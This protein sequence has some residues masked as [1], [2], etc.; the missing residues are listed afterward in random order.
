MA[1]FNFQKHSLLDGLWFRRFSVYFADD[2]S[3][4]T[5]GNLTTPAPTSISEVV[6]D[7]IPTQTTYVFRGYFR[8]NVTAANW[9]FRTNSDDASFVWFG[10]NAIPNTVDLDTAEAVVD[11]GTPH[12]ERERTSGNISMTAGLLYP[13]VII[14]GNSGGPGVIDFFA[15]SNGGTSFFTDMSDL[16]FY[17]PAYSNGFNPDS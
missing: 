6:L 17:D 16:V 2:P 5:A 15:S 14:V 12:V 3:N 8:P 1:I 13:I 7:P 4:L 11:N 10:E 9:Q